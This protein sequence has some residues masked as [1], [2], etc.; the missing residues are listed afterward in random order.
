MTSP[1]LRP[2]PERQAEQVASRL[3][4]NLGSQQKRE[5]LWD[6]EQPTPYPLLG[7]VET[8]MEELDALLIWAMRSG[9]TFP[10]IQDEEQGAVPIIIH[11]IDPRLAGYPYPSYPL[12]GPYME[13][14]V[15]GLSVLGKI[16]WPDPREVPKMV[17]SPLAKFLTVRFRWIAESPE[18]RSLGAASSGQANNPYLPFTVHTQTNGLRI[19]YSKTFAINFN[20]VLGAPSTPVKG[21]ILPGIHKFAGMDRGGRMHYDRATFSTPPDYTAH[22]M[23]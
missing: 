21:W 6:A 19:H 7:D 16:V 17:F 12:F 10:C 5:Y 2:D 15:E 13:E 22:L 23:I 18:F 8:A 11:P 14:A 20:G 3:T 4:K 1:P 9:S